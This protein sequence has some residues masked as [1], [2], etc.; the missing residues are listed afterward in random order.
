MTDYDGVNRFTGDFY[1]YQYF[2]NGK[3]SGKGW[4]EGYHFIPQR[5]CREALSFID[6]LGLNEKSYILDAGCAYGFLVRT[7]RYLEI[8]ADGCDI[9]KFALSHAPKGCW[10]CEDDLSWK[11]HVH[12]GYTHC[13]IKDML[14]HLTKQQ[15]IKMLHNIGL[16]TSRIMCVV[17]IGD[18]GI[19]RIPEYHMEI[20]HLIAEDEDWW[21]SAFE[22]NGWKIT[23]ETNHCPGLKDNW[24]HVPD[25]NHVFVLEKKQFC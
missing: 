17:P 22:N 2:Q 24:M 21:R 20:S 6:Y 13:V 14:E 18:N 8:P 9:S 16:V 4:L 11:E 7:F 3:Q 15:L 10:N 25:G 19:Y 23:K 1:D 12:F 5:S